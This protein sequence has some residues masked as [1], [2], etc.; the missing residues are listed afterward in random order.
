[1]TIRTPDV[2]R[3]TGWFAAGRGATNAGADRRATR[4]HTNRKTIVPKT[5]GQKSTSINA[6]TLPLVFGIGPAGTGKTY[7]AMAAAVRRS[8]KAKFDALSSRR[9]AGV[10]AGET[11]DFSQAPSARKSSPTSAALRCAQTTCS[12]R[13]H[14]AAHE[15]GVIEIAPLAICASHALARLSLDEAQNHHARQ[16][17][18]FLT[19]AGDRSRMVVTGESRRSICRAPS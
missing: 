16:M 2:H 7:L 10:E 11:P 12:K 6:E 4:H 17:M 14:R 1:M 18:M 15:K 19:R 13:G 5:A 8:S 3:I 9:P